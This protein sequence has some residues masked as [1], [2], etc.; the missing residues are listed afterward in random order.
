[1]CTV[2]LDNLFRLLEPAKLFEAASMTSFPIA[3]LEPHKA[4]S[5]HIGPG[6]SIWSAVGRREGKSTLLSGDRP[7]T[8]GH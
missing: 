7:D 6:V 4:V 3:L 5:N 1:M 2:H 8:K